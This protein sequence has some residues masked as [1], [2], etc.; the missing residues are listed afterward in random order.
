MNKNKENDQSQSSFIV[1]SAQ[2]R[3]SEIVALR[4]RLVPSYYMQG[5]ERHFREPDNNDYFCKIYREHFFQSFQAMNFCKNLK[6]VDP[7]ELNKRKVHLPRLDRHKGNIPPAF[8]WL[9]NKF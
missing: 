4:Q 8:A 2:S 6:D 1:E 3:E 9:T 7:K 5:L